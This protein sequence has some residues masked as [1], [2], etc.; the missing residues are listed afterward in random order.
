MQV[1]NS[2]DIKSATFRSTK[3]PSIEKAIDEFVGG[4]VE[5]GDEYYEIATYSASIKPLKVIKKVGTRLFFDDG[6]DTSN[7]SRKKIIPE[8]CR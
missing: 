2:N 3:L 8:G 1:K 5:N 4:T 6:T 7:W